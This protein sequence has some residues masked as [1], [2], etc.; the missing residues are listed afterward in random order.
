M[1]LLAAAVSL[2]A[3][4]APLH[5][6][7]TPPNELEFRD[8]I[9]VQFLGSAE[10]FG[11]R[12]GFRLGD[13]RRIDLGTSIT[14]SGLYLQDAL[15]ESVGA[16]LGGALSFP[17][18]GT[19]VEPFA[20]VGVASVDG[21]IEVLG[22]DVVTPGGGSDRLAF[23]EETSG[24]GVMWGGG[25][26]VPVRF[27]EMGFARV[28]LGY[29]SAGGAAGAQPGGL[30]LT[31]SLGAGIR[32]D[33][34]YELATDITLPQILIPGLAGSAADSVAAPD[35]SFQVLAADGNGIQ[36]I[37]AGPEELE[38]DE[39]TG[40]VP[41]ELTGS[42]SP[43]RATATV[44]AP[45]GGRE[46]VILAE[47][48]AGNVTRRVVRVFPAPDRDPPVVRERGPGRYGNPEWAVSALAEDFSGI[49]YAYTGVCRVPVV[50]PIEDPVAGETYEPGQRWIGGW[51]TEAGE[52]VDLT[53]QDRSGNAQTV[54]IP[55]TVA[56]PDQAGGVG[57]TA[58]VV[59]ERVLGDGR[60]LIRIEGRAAD[61]SGGWIRSVSVAGQPAALYID[62][63]P[64]AVRFSGWVTVDGDAS[65]VT[66][67]TASFDGRPGTLE[68][69]LPGGDRSEPATP[70][71]LHAVVVTGE[72]SVLEGQLSNRWEA[73][74]MDGELASEVAT[75]EELIA[76]IRGLATTADPGDMVWLHLEAELAGTLAGAVPSLSMNGTTISWD[77]LERLMQLLE[78]RDIVVSA[79]LRPGRSWRAVPAEVP[80]EQV[81]AGCFAADGSA[82]AGAVGLP[83]LSAERVLEL[84]GGAADAN[85]DG[86]ISIRE[87]LNGA[88]APREGLSTVPLDHPFLIVG[89]G[90]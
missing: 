65:S 90:R 2:G 89:G 50:V 52:T 20:E 55:T 37:L 80:G 11:Q 76:A 44:Q 6:Q 39:V 9:E 41:D 7:A 86:V 22:L 77:Y 1:G 40:G 19:V 5:A 23:F 43:V 75:A 35:G 60:R 78:G 45:F 62:G 74:G 30:R 33:P 15:S 38:V 47:D 63:A 28:G 29:W 61:G 71:R 27:G 4:S 69:E 24:V 31:A 73:L 81:R 72:G 54:R 84:M 82:T 17:L 36:R 57:V 25:L 46:L 85:L 14:L 79:R 21:R 13:Q 32:N 88:G 66:L 68:L 67:E 42:G 56:A 83:G 18:L 70:P 16:A 48:R 87:L 34:W 49:A 51:S 10:E 64:T 59:G 58:A 12:G 53:V 8:L 3:F 26:T